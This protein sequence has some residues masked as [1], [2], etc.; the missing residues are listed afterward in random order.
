MKS[1]RVGFLDFS[2]KMSQ[3]QLKNDFWR[4]GMAWFGLVMYQLQFWVNSSV[5][6]TKI[7]FKMYKKKKLKGPNFIN[8]R[9]FI[10]VPFWAI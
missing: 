5:A 8:L 3:K 1:I 6:E 7:D 4:L 9:G 2:H 10:K